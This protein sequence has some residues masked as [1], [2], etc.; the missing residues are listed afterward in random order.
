MER[1][2]LQWDLIPV[3]PDMVEA[4]TGAPDETVEVN[5][6]TAPLDVNDYS[7]GRSM[8]GYFDLDD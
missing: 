5:Q 6:K 4:E 8:T 7:I 1:I 2:W 3:S